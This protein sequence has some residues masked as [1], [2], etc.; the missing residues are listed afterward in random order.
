[1]PSHS[2]S[3]KR[4]WGAAAESMK[5]VEWV[6]YNTMHVMSRAVGVVFPSEL[7]QEAM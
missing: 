2:A 6:S 5:S 3:K 7:S 1:M 4:L